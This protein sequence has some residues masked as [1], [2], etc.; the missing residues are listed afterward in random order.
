MAIR[1]SDVLDTDFLDGYE[2]NSDGYGINSIY[3]TTSCISTTSGTK[4][5]VTGPATDGNGI[6]YTFDHPV[7]S[8]DIVWL[9]G[10]SGG[11][12]DGYFTINQVLSDTSFSVNETIGTSTGGNIQYRYKSGAKNIGFNPT[13]TSHITHNNV[14]QALEDL[15]ASIVNTGLTP[16]EHERL[17]QLIHLADGVGGPFEGFLSGAY[18]EMLPLGFIRPNTITWYDDAT[19]TKKIVQKT[20]TYTTSKLPATFTWDVYNTDGTTVLATVI[21]TLTYIG[22]FEAS[23]IRTITDFSVP[24][25]T[26]DANQHKVIRQLIHLAEGIGGPF[27]GFAS[28]AYRE[29]LPSA[30]AFPTSIIWYDDIT[31]TKK[32][33]EKTLTYNTN[34]SVSTVSWKVYNTDGLTVLATVTDTINYS[35]IFETNR[36]RTIV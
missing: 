30:N 3:L 22:V 20:I 1:I 27:E 35:G 18:R 13:N 8:G 7:E 9:T 17:R 2:L 16:I 34:K 14:Q 32:I 26:L 24:T 31:K 19:K 23:R 21:D 29:I 5:V 4:I 33:V 11:L 10:T 12:G 6:L 25:G 36:T 28:G 15:D